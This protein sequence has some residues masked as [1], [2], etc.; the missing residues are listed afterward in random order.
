MNFN[1]KAGDKA[2]VIRE[3]CGHHFP[4]GEIVT[5][6][7]LASHHEHFQATNGKDDWYLSIYEVLPY[8]TIKNNILEE[9][10]N[11]NNCD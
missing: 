8:E 7:K 1:Y 11:E 6:V 10:R 5:V 4:L 3:I 2:I 9:I